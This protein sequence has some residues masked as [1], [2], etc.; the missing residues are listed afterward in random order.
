M[1]SR[2]R[3]DVRR[4]CF[5]AV[6]KESSSRTKG[7]FTVR[8]ECPEYLVVPTQVVGCYVPNSLPRRRGKAW[9][10]WELYSGIH[11]LVTVGWMNPSP[12]FI[13]RGCRVY[14]TDGAEKSCRTRRRKRG[15]R[16]GKRRSRGCQPRRSA[17]GPATASKTPSSRKVNH[18]GRKFL[19]A[20]KASNR[21]RKD[22]ERLNKFP[23]GHL[24]DSHPAAGPRRRMREH[25]EVKWA[26][27]HSR[28]TASGIPPVAAFHSSFWKYLMVETSRGNAAA[29]W[30]ML[31]AHLPGNPGLDESPL[32]E[33]F[34]AI[35]S[36]EVPSRKRPRGGASP[37]R[38]NRGRVRPL[39]RR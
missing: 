17:A 13:L 30:D 18:S 19:W 25:C 5:G 4:R 16:K 22:C 10:S 27:L 9:P 1:V 8:V 14:S 20:V 28:A 6:R 15:L 29:D 26:R 23:R 38:N 33:A 37:A 39:R 2:S 11:Q 12:G 31:L 7:H 36:G 24:S 21:F 35:R 34:L 3:C 32:T